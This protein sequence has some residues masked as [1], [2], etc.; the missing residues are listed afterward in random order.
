IL[1]WTPFFGVKD[2]G[3]GIGRDAFTKAKCPV[4]NCMTT[5]DRNLVNQSDAIIFH[6]FDVNVKDLPTYRTAHQRYIL[7][8][9][10]A[11]VSHRNF[12]NCDQILDDYKFYVSAENSIC[13]DYITEKF[14]RALEMG[15]V[16][17]VYGGA[18]YS[19]YAP[20]HSYINAA[21]FESP[22]ALADYLLL[23]ERNPRLYSEYLDWNKD[24]EINKQKQSEG[25]C[26]LCEKLNAAAKSKEQQPKNNSASKVYR[27]MAKWY[28]E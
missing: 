11:Y 7:F 18:D 10:E 14:Y 1:F 12:P 2:Y 15:V 6:P 9:Y 3:F 23:I 28:Y 13:P 4:N 5:T 21:D 22:Q 25:W 26:R 8:F 27:D 20:P 19:A 17:V 16:P 24:W